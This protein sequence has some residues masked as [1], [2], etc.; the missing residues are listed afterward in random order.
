MDIKEIQQN[1]KK[2]L[3][4]TT[5]SEDELRYVQKPIGKALYKSTLQKRGRPR[6]N[7]NDKCKP[8]DKVQCKICNKIYTRSG[9][10]KHKKTQY[11]QLHEKMNIKLRKVLMD[12]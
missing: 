7:K 8:N 10:T 6:I 11:H 1:L 12:P 2:G 9:S 5:Y 4:L 3:S